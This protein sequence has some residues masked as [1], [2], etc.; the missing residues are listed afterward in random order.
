MTK[1]LFHRPETQ[2]RNRLL[3]V[4]LVAGSLAACAPVVISADWTRFLGPDGKSISTDS[5]KIPETWSDTENVRWKAELPGAGVSSPIVV[6]GKLFVTS[7]SGY[8][9]GGENEKIEDLK[10]HLSCFDAA[11]GELKWTKTVDAV[12]PEDPY[13]G[14]GV[15]AHG[16]AS[17]TPTSDGKHVF[18]FFG[19]T[20]VIAFD[21]D[22]NEVWR[23]SVGTGSGPMQWG[24]AASPIVY[25]AGDKSMVIVNASDESET[26][27]AFDAATGKEVW[28][29]EAGNLANSWSTPNLVKTGDDVDLVIMVPGEVWGLN[30]ETGKLRWYSR[31]TTDN[32]ASASPIAIG[33]TVFAVGGRDGAAVAVKAGG[34]DDVNDSNVVWDANIPG[35]FATPIAHDGHLYVFNGGVLTCYDAKTG[36]RVNQRRFSEARQ[37]GGG[38]RPGGGFGGGGFG[39]RAPGG[40]GPGAGGPGGGGP[41]GGGRGGRGGGFGGGRSTQEYAT[42]V[43]ADGKI[44]VVA[45]G[46][47]VYVVNATPEMELRQTNKLTDDSGFS[48]SPAIS[49]G[50]LYLRS[51]N[52][53]YCIAE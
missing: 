4:A 19:K 52:N 49:D 32:T 29:T 50:R 34:K 1:K 27:F 45:P 39:G 40:R 30:P 33:D 35:R 24:S 42:P 21:F 22:G 12:Q 53:V 16:Y 15:P 51:G 9:M 7:Y 28:K 43:L 14:A 8:G 31:G 20:G 3:S 2:V 18:V 46:G 11:N 26:L 47:Q 6:G 17:H 13:R 48:A 37:G 36:D 25:T 5:A 44:Y 38:D 41:G 23:Q 10:R